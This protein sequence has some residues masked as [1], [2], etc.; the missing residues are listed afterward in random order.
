MRKIVVTVRLE[1]HAK[2]LFAAGGDVTTGRKIY[3]FYVPMDEGSYGSFERSVA[4]N[5]RL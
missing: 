5:L 3:E 1:E 2:E 4:E